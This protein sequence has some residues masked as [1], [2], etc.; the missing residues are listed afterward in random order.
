MLMIGL[1]S[2]TSAD[3]VDAALVRWPDDSA[4]KPFELL[5]EIEIPHST[6]V[7][8]RIHGLADG[9]VAASRVLSELVALDADLGESFAAAAR[10]VADRA[11]VALAE[12]D[13]V[14]SHGQTLAHHPERGGTL[15]VG[16]ASV[17]AERTG[18]TVVAD[19]RPGDLALGGEGAPLAP[20]FHHAVFADPGETR[21]VLNLGGIANVTFLP[22]SALAD[23]VI[24]FDVGPANSLLDGVV[25]QLT[26]GREKMDR[27]GARAL[28]GT[29]HRELLAEL[30][31]DEYLQRPP[32][33]STG[34]E[35]YGSQACQDLMRRWQEIPEPKT[36]DDLLATLVAFTAEAVGQACRE[37]LKPE[38]TSLDRL[39]VGGGGAHNPAVMAGLRKTLPGVP[40]DPFDL[41]GVPVGAAE[42]MAFSLLGRNTLLGLPNHLPRCTGAR[43]AGVLGVVVPRG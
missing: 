22:A 19:F 37:W 13:G 25:S 24:A 8:E 9:H 38:G 35:R 4:C 20:F 32:P 6:D 34:R 29:V 42:A 5:A 14:A 31:A 7:R 36:A 33:K 40:V 3:A 1:M 2:G 41:H 11:G 26:E 18:C 12:V 15:Q 39:L 43:H 27:G 10:A 17:L 28:A 23:D 30:M 21:A 16:S